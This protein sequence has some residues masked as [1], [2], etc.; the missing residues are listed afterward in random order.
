MTGY[1]EHSFDPNAGFE[2]ARPLKPYD[3]WQWVGIGAMALAAVL[4]VASILFDK[5]D[6]WARLGGMPS[7][8][9]F[10]LAISG[11]LLMR[12]RREPTD[13]EPHPESSERRRRIVGLVLIAL[14]L[15]AVAYNIF[16]S[17]GA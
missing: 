14:A 2:E 17:Q 11:A 5:A 6:G 9:G 7:G 8:A 13:D 3:K 12:Y 10:L 1:R 15:A 16:A 4:L